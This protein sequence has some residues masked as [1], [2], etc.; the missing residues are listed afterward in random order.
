MLKLIFAI[1]IIFSVCPAYAQLL[2]N[3]GRDI[4]NS[5][6]HKVRSKVNEKV[7]QA[8]DSVT[9]KPKKESKPASTSPKQTATINSTTKKSSSSEETNNEDEMSIGEGFIKLF[10]SANEVFRHGMVLITG[11][12]VKYGTLDHVD[13]EIKGPE[14]DDMQLKL[15]ADGSFTGNWEPDQS[16]EYTITAKSSDGKSFQSA[17][18]TVIDIEMTDWEEADNETDEA[19]EKLRK[20]VERAK[21]HI[22]AKDKAEL[23][24]RMDEVEEKVKIVKDLYSN[25]SAGM[26]GLGALL[27]QGHSLSPALAKDLSELNNV[28]TEQRR[29]M[30]KMNDAAKHEPYDN[31]ICEYLVMINEACA[32]F[33]T[34][35]NFW[36]KSVTTI[37]K[38]V[39]MDKVIPKGV[40]VV[41]AKKGP[42]P[43]D[44]DVIAKQPAKLFAAA[45]FD[46]EALFGKMGMAGFTGDLVQFASDM[47]MKKY[48]GI[49]KGELKHDY[50]I[51]YRN[52]AGAIWWK[53]NYQTTAAVTFRYPKSSSGKLI[54]MKGNI[55][56]NVTKFGFFQDIER[57]EGFQEQMKGRAKLI[58]VKIYHPV[59]VPFATS[60][61]D[62]LGFGSVAKGLAT[63]AYFNI[64]LDADYDTDAETIKLF[65]NNAL[66]DFTPMVKYVYGYI[67]I[68]AGIPL[69]TRVDFP[70]NKAKLTLDAVVRENNELK[71]TKDSKNKLVV[72][73]GG[74]RQIG[75]ATSPIEHTINYSLTA[76][77]D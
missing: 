52:N 50:T 62:E 53:Y 37:I 77:N 18:V 7:N 10:V 33:S 19:A 30:E 34:F 70:V 49:F 64:P 23:E 39:V 15:F 72:K 56:G 9:T 17:K 36:S 24:K 73:G 26:K 3:I 60:Q 69:V 75:N 25:L 32:A 41:N 12:S 43:G 42:L 20:E 59:A 47:L 48:C 1:A 27:K 76:K 16:G 29:Q 67:A 4:K 66:I 46:S 11:N 28:I 54:K 68:A 40:E 35:T 51:T 71:V 55:E 5:A 8:I 13:I 21:A 44:Y 45:K 22:G 74:T 61:Y 2:K 65:L 58:P 57:M 14:P 63:P 31:T 38:N 6:E